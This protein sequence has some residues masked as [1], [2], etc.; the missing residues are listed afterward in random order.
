MSL[1]RIITIIVFLERVEILRKDLEFFGKILFQS[2]FWDFRWFI[3]GSTGLTINIYGFARHRNDDVC[4]N[5]PWHRFSGGYPTY[6]LGLVWSLNFNLFQ[7][8][9]PTFISMTFHPTS[10]PG[11]TDLANSVLA[12]GNVFNLHFPC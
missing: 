4:A 1:N 6:L 2:E 12:N 5:L 10:F 11:L 7:F 9:L 8:Y 3:K